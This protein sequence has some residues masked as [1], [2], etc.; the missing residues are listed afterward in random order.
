MGVCESRSMHRI[1]GNKIAMARPSSPRSPAIDYDSTSKMAGRIQKT[2]LMF[3]V[4]AAAAGAVLWGISRGKQ[5]PIGI[6]TNLR[7]AATSSTT[8]ASAPLTKPAPPGDFVGVVRDAY[9]DFPATEPLAIPAELHEGARLVLPEPIYLDSMQ[10]LWITRTDAAPTPK[11]L[12]SAGD[13]Q[14]HLTRE[15]V[16]FVHR[17]LDDN[18]QWQPQ[19]V[20]ADADGNFVLLSTDGR[21]N[22]GKRYRY[23]WDRALDWNSTTNEGFV[24]P[25]DTGVSVFRPR[26][27]PV[28]LHYDFAQP[29]TAPATETA[30]TAA[31]TQ[32]AAS[33]QGLADTT[34]PSAPPPTSNAQFLLDTRGLLAWIPWEGNKI[35]SRGAAR[36]VD[37]AWQPLGP[38]QGW[39]EK[40]LHLI[41]LIG[42]GVL[43][44]VVNDDGTVAE[45]RAQLDAAP[46]DPAAV[47]PLIDQLSDPDP[48]VRDAASNELTRY[49]PGLWPL[50]EKAL[51]DQPPEGHMRIERLLAAKQQP[52]LGAMTLLPGNVHV[53]AHLQDNGELLLADAGVSVPNNDPALPPIV[54]APAYISIRPDRPVELAPPPLVADLAPDARFDVAPDE[55]IET[56]DAHGPRRLLGNHLEALLHK[57][58]RQFSQFVGIDR[59]GRWLFREPKQA[60]PTLVLDPNLPDATPRI[61]AWIDPLACDVVGWDDAG[62]PVFM[63]NNV[64][65]GLHSEEWSPLPDGPAR[66]FYKSLDD[67]PAAAAVPPTKISATTS[68]SHPVPIFSDSD[69][70]DYFDGHDT[71]TVHRADG[72]TVKWPLPPAAVGD[73]EVHLLRAADHLFLF[74]Q[75]GRLLRIAATPHAAEPFKLEATFTRQ[76]PNA[77]HFSRVW[78]DP[79]GRIDLEYD[80]NHLTI[81]FPDGRIPRAISEKMP[82]EQLKSD[83]D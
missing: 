8:P 28:E 39:P 19:I 68:T 50:L 49:G 23:R 35:G 11:V 20:F 9:P 29:T 65:W 67:M 42:G 70:T 76:I 31:A 43:Q 69:G 13:D 64:A 21:L 48:K 41:P 5:L 24:V 3:A 57:S 44:L 60:T 47:N 7:P 71:L 1:V 15:H 63:K 54:T 18:S 6:D 4:T 59:R 16:L 58:E 38:D 51:D 61:A 78:L 56:D 77:D 14:V 34:A 37:G 36:F 22:L 40:L 2:V 17:F 45:Q 26:S 72:S 81:L 80:T 74:N 12:K 25:T 82:A 33:M 62:W 73:G 79:A 55:W 75:P 66:K 46:V 53:L 32:P 52:T 30:T 27:L 10:E 83:D